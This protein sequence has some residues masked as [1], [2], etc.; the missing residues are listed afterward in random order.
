MEINVL[1]KYKGALLFISWG[2]KLW[3][4]LQFILSIIS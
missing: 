4:I 3:I 1:Y 2:Y